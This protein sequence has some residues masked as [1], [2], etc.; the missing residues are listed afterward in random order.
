MCIHTEQTRILIH[1][2]SHFIGLWANGGV[3]WEEVKTKQ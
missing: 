1:M 2:A 3:G